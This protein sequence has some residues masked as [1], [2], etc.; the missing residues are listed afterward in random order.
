[1]SELEN[2]QL[3]CHLWNKADLTAEDLQASLVNIKEYLDESH[4]M[5]SLKRCTKC[6]QLYLYQ[7]LEE[8]DWTDSEDEQ[9]RIWIPVGNIEKADEL[10]VL[11]D[12]ELM[13]Y[14]RLAQDWPKNESK[15][16]PIKKII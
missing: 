10:N 11:S 7:I 15:A 13:Q 8:V 3:A 2:N 4:L 5:R 12:M 6:G 9:Y 1:M 16:L 14:P